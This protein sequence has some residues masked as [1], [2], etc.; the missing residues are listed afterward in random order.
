MAAACGRLILS[1]EL[2]QRLVALLNTFD[3][4]LVGKTG[5]VALR[6]PR[7]P[8][9]SQHDDEAEGIRRDYS[10]RAHQI[11][12]QIS[13]NRQHWEAYQDLLEGVLAVFKKELGLVA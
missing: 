12:S 13:D 4:Y 10:Q 5:L 11:A 2:V 6:S 9:E 8:E 3:G 1:K 7:Y